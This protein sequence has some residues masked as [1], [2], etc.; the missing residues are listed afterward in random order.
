M[1]SLVSIIIVVL[2]GLSGQAVADA[3][4]AREAELKRFLEKH[5]KEM[6]KWKVVLVNKGPG[7]SRYR[8]D[9]QELVIDGDHRK[10]SVFEFDMS[11][12]TT[13]GRIVTSVRTIRRYGKSCDVVFGFMYKR[14]SV[15]VG[16][17]KPKTRT[18]CDTGCFQLQE[19]EKT[20]YGKRKRFID[21]K[22]RCSGDF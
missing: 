2:L 1:K 7:W 4:A 13:I 9:E 19:W 15:G 3:D 5:R 22:E 14:V 16:R 12:E 11:D 21:V 17:T 20:E 10:G 18:L 8:F 6:E